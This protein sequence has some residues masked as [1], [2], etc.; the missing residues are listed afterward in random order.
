MLFP[1]LTTCDSTWNK[2]ARAT[3]AGKLGVA[4]K[5]ATRD[6]SGKFPV[7]C[8]YTKDM[9]DKED[10]KRVLFELK[11][12]GVIREKQRYYYKPGESYMFL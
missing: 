4:C 12:L 6:D 7:L 3:N 1:S 10:V 5:I 11:G 2:V 9:M 8:V